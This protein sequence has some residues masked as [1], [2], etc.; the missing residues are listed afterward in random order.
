MPKIDRDEVAKLLDLGHTSKKIAERLDCH[1]DTIR[2]IRSEIGRSH[3]YRGR[4]MTDARALTI[5]RML[6]DGWSHAEIHATE[7]VDVSTIRHYFPGTAWTHQQAGEYRAVLRSVE[8]PTYATGAVKLGINHINHD[9]IAER[10]Q[11]RQRAAL[12]A[13]A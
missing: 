3:P 9:P 12:K 8:S 2:R 13:A 6:F 10:R 1:P 5:W 11:R 4:P 7:G